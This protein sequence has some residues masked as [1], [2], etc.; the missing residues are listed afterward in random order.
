MI[1]TLDNHLVGVAFGVRYRAN[2][3]IEDQLGSIIDQILYSKNSFFNEQ[4]FPLTEGHINQKIL[5][6]E[7]TGDKLT[8]NNSNAILEINFGGTFKKSDLGELTEQFQKE[9]IEGVLKKQK[10]TQ[11]VR[12]GL[13]RRYLFEEKDLAKNFISKTIGTIDGVNDIDLRFSKKFPVSDSLTSK[14]IYDY[15]NVIFN[16][17]KASNRQELFMAIDYQKYFVPFLESASGIEFPNFIKKAEN[18]NK[19]NYI[20]WLNSN[21]LLK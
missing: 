10:V 2:F 6:N 11:I 15:E 4:I 8:I 3:S 13:I 5:L 9:I 19:K 18:F 12:V 17:I 21:Y 7:K 14:E 20:E 16:V 1:E